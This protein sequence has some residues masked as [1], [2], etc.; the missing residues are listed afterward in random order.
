M[1]EKVPFHTRKIMKKKCSKLSWQRRVK[2]I[3][4]KKDKKTLSLNS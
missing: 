2:K 1:D 3:N 4:R